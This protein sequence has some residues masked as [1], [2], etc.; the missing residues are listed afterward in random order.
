M[1]ST[2]CIGHIQGS[3]GSV[4]GG[5]ELQH[6]VTPL[7]FLPFVRLLW[8]QFI[9]RLVPHSRKISRIWKLFISMSKSYIYLYH[10]PYLTHWLWPFSNSQIA[11]VPFA[12]ERQHD[13][14]TMDRTRGWCIQTWAQK[15][16]SSYIAQGDFTWISWDCHLSFTSIYTCKIW[17]RLGSIHKIVVTQEQLAKLGKLPL[18]HSLACYAGILFM[19]IW[20]TAI[21]R[22]WKTLYVEYSFFGR[23][24]WQYS[25]NGVVTKCSQTY[26][27]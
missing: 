23:E 19:V 9:L 12:R 24:V 13:N 11:L 18:M 16:K 7:S 5:T 20:P 27:V 22:L 17:I 14:W 1:P 2:P 10:I 25:M 6:S 3:L 26:R 21:S 8:S 4:V 15:K